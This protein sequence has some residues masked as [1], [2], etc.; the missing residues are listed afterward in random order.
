MSA[1]LLAWSINGWALVI[2]PSPTPDASVCTFPKYYDLEGHAGL[3]S[4]GQILASPGTRTEVYIDGAT[5]PNYWTNLPFM[6]I[7]KTEWIPLIG[8]PVEF[9][10]GIPNVGLFIG[11]AKVGTPSAAF[12]I[13]VTSAQ[14]G[15]ELKLPAGSLS[16][17]ANG[18]H[19]AVVINMYIGS[20]N[21]NI[22]NVSNIMYY[23][24]GDRAATVK[25]EY[26]PGCTLHSLGSEA[27][28]FPKISDSVGDEIILIW[29]ANTLSIMPGSKIISPIAPEGPIKVSVHVDGYTTDSVT[30][31]SENLKYYTWY[32]FL[33]PIRVDSPRPNDAGFYRA[34][35]YIPPTPTPTPSPTPTASPVPTPLSPQD[36]ILYQLLGLEPFPTPAADANGDGVLDI[37]DYYH[38]GAAP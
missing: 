12:V 27:V 18:Y 20:K 5:T 28:V 7:Y 6:D 10:I 19:G 35:D 1:L 13:P 38:L 23:S 16:P 33:K 37:A 32:A 21:D 2:T 4:T 22:C 15:R 26:L 9:R 3:R 24:S 25:V 34:G 31:A 30:I 29:G 14:L 11:P 36:A 8:R 17:T